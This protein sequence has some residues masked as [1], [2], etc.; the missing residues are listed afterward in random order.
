MHTLS[1][2]EDGNQETWAAVHTQ[3]TLK[4]APA[5]TLILALCQKSKHFRAGTDGLCLFPYSAE[6]VQRFGMRALPLQEYVDALAAELEET[7]LP[8]WYL[9]YRQPHA[10]GYTRVGTFF[11]E[12]RAIHEMQTLP[13][14]HPDDHLQLLKT[15]WI[16]S[17]ALEP[18]DLDAQIRR[19][20]DYAA[21]ARVGGAADQRQFFHTPLATKQVP[22]RRMFQGNPW[23]DDSKPYGPDGKRKAGLN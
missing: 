18:L 21:G 3:L 5:S 16:V 1:L 12:G 19:I 8:R 10:T 9:Y 20:Q 4:E 17:P 2:I 7:P 22:P 23:D 6:A 14:R 15:Y 13:D 11:H